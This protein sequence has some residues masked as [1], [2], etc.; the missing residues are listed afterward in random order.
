MMVVEDFYKKI[1]EH[2]PQRIRREVALAS[3]TTWRIGGAAEFFFRPENS[4]E[5][6]VAISLAREY[7]IPVAILGG[8]S[9]VLISDQGIAGLVIHMSQMKTVSWLEQGVVV[10]A[11]YSLP[12]LAQM[13]AQ[14]ELAG[15][16][17]AAG[18]PGTL[19]G[20]VLMNAGAH[21]SEMA[22]VVAAVSVVTPEGEIRD[23]PG[24]QLDFAYRSSALKGSGQ[25]ITEIKLILKPG[26]Q[27]ASKELM[28][29]ILAARKEKQPYQYPNAGSVFKN[30]PQDAAGRLIEEAGGKGLTVGG[31]QVSTKHA[32]FIVNL[33]GATADDVFKLIKEVQALVFQKFGFLLETEIVML[34]FDNNGR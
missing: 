16:E 27:A 25:L 4:E 11:G 2:F 18:I 14:K 34:G 6:A 23:L 24:S 30:P 22:E 7:D 32:N 26:N 29:K 28:A 9:N 12:K 13:A 19:G 21:G 17:F 10:G 3:Y 1:S 8:G 33:G 20:A 15:L 31:A 5:C